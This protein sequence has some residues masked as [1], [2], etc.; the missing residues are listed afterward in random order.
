MLTQVLRVEQGSYSHPW[1]LG[2]FVDSL[3]RVSSLDY[4]DDSDPLSIKVTEISGNILTLSQDLSFSAEN[5]YK[6]NLI[7]FPD[8]GAPYRIL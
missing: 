7:G 2:N 4:V 6:I 8:K 5:G 3:V 1:Q